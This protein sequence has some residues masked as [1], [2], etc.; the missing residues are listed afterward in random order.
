MKITNFSFKARPTITRELRALALR[1]KKSVD[2]ILQ[3]I[4]KQGLA[5]EAEDK[6]WLD[7]ATK[8]DSEAKKSRSI[9]HADAW[10]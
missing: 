8:R 9:R 10:R 3:R 2:V 1:E 4:V 5:V 7:L 6:A